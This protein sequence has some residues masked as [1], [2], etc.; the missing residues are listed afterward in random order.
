M[1]SKFRLALCSDY[2]YEDVVIYIDWENEMIAILDQEKGPENKEIE[3]FSAAQLTNS[4]FPFKA[5]KNCL[6][7]AEKF[8]DDSKKYPD[9]EQNTE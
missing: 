7:E 4:K 2:T 9:E 3:L 5:F 8:L 1:K 6:N